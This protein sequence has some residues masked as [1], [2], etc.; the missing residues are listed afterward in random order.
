MDQESVPKTAFTSKF[1]NYEFLTLPYGLT[2][3]PAI[4]QR[5]MD[6]I[7]APFIRDGRVVVYLDDICIASKYVK[8]HLRDVMEVCAVLEAYNLK[9]NEAKCFFAQDS[10]KFLGHEI[11]R[12]GTHT[13]PEK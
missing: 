7:L 13:E 11:S 2:N 8:D 5:M 12:E 10:L 6:T 3:A 1:G 4:F 9:I